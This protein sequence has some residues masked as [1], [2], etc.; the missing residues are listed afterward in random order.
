MYSVVCLDTIPGTSS[1]GME[2]PC[3][4]ESMLRVVN[5]TSSRMNEF[6]VFVLIA[7]VASTLFMTGLIWFVQVVHYPLK[8]V[9]GTNAFVTYQAAHVQRTGMVVAVP[10]LVEAAS[11]LWMVWRPLPQGRIVLAWVAL[12]ILVKVW[13]VTAVYSVQAHQRLSSGFDRAVHRT[14]VGTNWMRT[15]GWSARSILVL[16]YAQTVVQGGL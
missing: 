11:A 1:R 2:R 6:D 4:G 10:M 3:R 12:L 9:V 8:A 5:A 15:A 13:V 7:H 16:W 14:L